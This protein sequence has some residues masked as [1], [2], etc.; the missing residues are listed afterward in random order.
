VT[1]PWDS[2]FEQILRAQL[3]GAEPAADTPLTN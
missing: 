1:V 3:P 2:T